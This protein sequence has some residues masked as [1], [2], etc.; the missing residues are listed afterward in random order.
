MLCARQPFL[1]DIEMLF[2]ERLENPALCQAILTTV[3][4]GAA[5]GR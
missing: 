3:S 4:D 1:S 5:V 2:D